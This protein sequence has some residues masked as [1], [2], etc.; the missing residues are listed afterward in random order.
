[1]EKKEYKKG[2]PT[3]RAK[4]IAV[5]AYPATDDKKMALNFKFETPSG[6]L[7]TFFGR[8]STPATYDRVRSAVEALGGKGTLKFEIGRVVEIVCNTDD[9]TSVDYI[10]TFRAS[11]VPADDILLTVGEALYKDTGF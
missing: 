6:S 9:P 2:R 8:L 3:Y 4:L 10:N 7:H 11:K 5:E 1:M